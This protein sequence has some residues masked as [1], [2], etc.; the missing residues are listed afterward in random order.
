MN[1]RKLR[2]TIRLVFTASQHLVNAVYL[3]YCCKLTG[4]MENEQ[5]ELMKSERWQM[6]NEREMKRDRNGAAYK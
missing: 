2:K 6:G 1:K 5:E 3:F 4:L